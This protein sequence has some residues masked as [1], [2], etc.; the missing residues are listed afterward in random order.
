MLRKH[1][2]N[3]PPQL[4]IWF[5]SVKGFKTHV[6]KEL[7]RDGKNLDGNVNMTEE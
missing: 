1:V 5:I 3:E 2:S 4:V 7:F 6:N